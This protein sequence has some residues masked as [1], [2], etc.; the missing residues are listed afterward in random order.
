MDTED[1][2]EAACE[3]IELLA[4][5]RFPQATR[6]LANGESRCCLGVMRDVCGSGELDWKDTL[7]DCCF[8][9]DQFELAKLNDYR[10]THPEIA[11]DVL[12]N[13]RQYFDPDV[14]EGVA[15]YFWGQS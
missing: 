4:E 5:A 12:R 9:H 15:E 8:P 13:L 1:K 2:I 14:A 11:R 7:E 6:R 10:L 3:W